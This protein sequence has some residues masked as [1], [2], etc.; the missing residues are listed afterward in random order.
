MVARIAALAAACA[1]AAPVEAAP[2]RPL[3]L[4]LRA[5][6][7]AST[8]PSWPAQAAPLPSLLDR[9]DFEHHPFRVEAGLDVGTPSLSV[10]LDGALVVEGDLPALT[11]RFR[12]RTPTG[13]VEVPLP[14]LQVAPTWIAGQRVWEARLRLLSLSF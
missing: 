14:L 6:A 5:P 3:A 11:G 13:G 9:F 10:R 2:R 7:P 1:L 8:S 4:S 12:L